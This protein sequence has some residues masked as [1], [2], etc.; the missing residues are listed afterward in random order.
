MLRNNHFHSWLDKDKRQGKCGEKKVIKKV[1]WEIIIA[2]FFFCFCSLWSV[3]KQ[4]WSF[5]PLKCNSLINFYPFFSPPI[6]CFASLFHH[7]FC[8]FDFILFFSILS[9]IYRKI[10]WFF[11]FA[12]RFNKFHLVLLSWIESNSRI[13]HWSYWCSIRFVLWILRAGL[14]FAKTRYF[15][16]KYRDWN[17]PRLFTR[18]VEKH[19]DKVFLYYKDEKWTYDDVEQFSNRIANYFR[20]I[21]FRKNDEIALVMNTR[22]EFIATW[23][24]LSKCGIV[25]AFINTNQRMETLVHS[26]TVVNCKAVIFDVT[27]AKS[28][29]IYWMLIAYFYG[30]NSKIFPTNRYSR[31]SI[32]DWE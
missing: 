16:Y 10:S 17:V 7:L 28:K 29:R 3:S 5:D 22:P 25:T 13:I 24:G 20:S 31:G 11:F 32:D 26:I 23:L 12:K 14:A 1:H 9:I 2:K 19:P 15:L 18:L 4:S 8:D 27:L 6:H 30:L 21:G